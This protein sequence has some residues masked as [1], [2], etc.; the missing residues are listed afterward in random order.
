MA[1]R[2]SAA[3]AKQCERVAGVLQLALMIRLAV[4]RVMLFASRKGWALQEG[5]ACACALWYC[6]PSG[7]CRPMP[8][9][10][11]MRLHVYEAFV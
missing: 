2:L 8:C 9:G 10:W 4:T 1:Q 7:L 6:I 11:Y 5:C 3:S